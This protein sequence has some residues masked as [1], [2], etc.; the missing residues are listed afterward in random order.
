VSDIMSKM[1]HETPIETYHR[2]C[3]SGEHIMTF[4]NLSR[5]GEDIL[6]IEFC[7]ICGKMLKK[8]RLLCEAVD[9]EGGDAE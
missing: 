5:E 3:L 9:N 2:R 1:P 6:I 4:M 7:A 8:Y